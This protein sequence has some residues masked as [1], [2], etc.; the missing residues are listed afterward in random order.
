MLTGYLLQGNLFSY[1]KLHPDVLEGIG[2]VFEIDEAVLVQRQYNR[3]RS[4][5]QQW[6][7]AMVEIGTSKCCFFTIENTRRE[8]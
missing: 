4:I 8:T 2:E 5:R 1:L 7:F 6:I 3:G